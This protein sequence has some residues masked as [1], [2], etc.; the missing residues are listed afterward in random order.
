MRDETDFARCLVKVQNYIDNLEQTNRCRAERAEKLAAERDA[1][2]ARVDD[3][4]NATMSERGIEDMGWMKC[5]VDRDGVPIR[6]GE[7]VY[8]GDGKAWYVK[9]VGTSKHSVNG[10]QGAEMRQMR[11]RWLTHEPPK[12]FPLDA[13]GVECHVGDAIWLVA[14]SGKG[15]IIGIEDDG[16]VNVAWR[17]SVTACEDPKLFTHAEPDSWE[18]L[19]ADVKKFGGLNGFAYWGCEGSQCS[20]C[21]AVLGGE[22]PL[23]RYG[24]D[25]CSAAVCPDIVR[26][27]RALAGA[28]PECSGAAPK[29]DDEE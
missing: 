19:E 4:E 3:L 21:P 5:P 28:A 11:P 10:V 8:G 7:T 15:K 22:T 1:L 20:D 18:R 23:Q 9:H 16:T 24:V 17:A 14:G 13:D 29:G 6:P 2:Q 25:F 12:R 26:R 27:A